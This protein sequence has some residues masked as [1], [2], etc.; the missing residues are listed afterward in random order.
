MH[1]AVI[2]TVVLANA[3]HAHALLLW[4]A[5]VFVGGIVTYRRS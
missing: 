4:V 2:T 5:L 3:H 1:S